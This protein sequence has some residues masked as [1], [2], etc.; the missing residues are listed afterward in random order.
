LPYFLPRR[1]VPAAR[2][3]P[4]RHSC[5][6]IFNFNKVMMEFRRGFSR[7]TLGRTVG[8]GHRSAGSVAALSSSVARLL[9]SP[10]R[11]GTRRQA[12]KSAGRGSSR[13]PAPPRR[14]G[15][16]RQCGVRDVRGGAGRRRRAVLCRR[17]PAGRVRRR[18]RPDQ[19]WTVDGISFHVWAGRC[20]VYRP[21]W[22][23]F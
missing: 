1:P 7:E 12:K 16:L 10:R 20:L 4:N 2:G 3:S 8:G 19:G 22:S 9:A 15:S 6:R 23:D 13:R 11:R 21:G 17:R 14:N 18:L 5:P